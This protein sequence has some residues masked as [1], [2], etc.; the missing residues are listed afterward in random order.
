MWYRH[1]AVSRGMEWAMV[2]NL[3]PMEWDKS[4]VVTGC[5]YIALLGSEY[6]IYGECYIPIN[7]VV[8]IDVITQS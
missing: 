6:P 7:P 2:L 1:A 4:L 3:A 8:S 5:N